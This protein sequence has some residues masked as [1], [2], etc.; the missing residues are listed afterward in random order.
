MTNGDIIKG[1]LKKTEGK[2]QDAFGKATDSTEDRIEGNL[3]QA[4]GEIQEGFGKM[5]Q[6]V[7]NVVND[8]TRD[9]PPRT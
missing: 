2:A 3:K 1:K 4:E 8:T 6:A 9:H 7:K 5:K